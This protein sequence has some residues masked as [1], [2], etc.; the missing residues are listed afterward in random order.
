MQC[1]HHSLSQM[2]LFGNHLCPASFCNSQDLSYCSKTLLIGDGNVGAAEVD[3]GS[4]E[5]VPLEPKKSMLRGEVAGKLDLLRDGVTASD[6]GVARV[7]LRVIDTNAAAFLEALA[8]EPGVV[9]A[10]L[11]FVAVCVMVTGLTINISAW[12]DTFS[13]AVFGLLLLL[14]SG[15][16]V[17]VDELIHKLLVVT[18]TIGKHASVVTVVVDTPLNFDHFTGFVGRYGL[19]TPVAAWFVV[20]VVATLVESTR[21]ALS[22][23]S[24]IEIGPRIYRLQNG[25][26]GALILPSLLSGDQLAC[27]N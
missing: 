16:V 21:A 4:L 10:W 22:N 18:Q 25:T 20:V 8:S 5:G 15:L 14:F 2:L 27:E 24:L 19:L 6:R 23:F 26:L 3:L 12:Q 1:N 7:L 17:R 11:S 9:P 13:E